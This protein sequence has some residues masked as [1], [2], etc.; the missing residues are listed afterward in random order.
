[1]GRY[2]DAVNCFE[3]VIEL[4]PGSA[5]DY[6]N[7]GI[8]L[9]RLGHTKEAAFVLRQALELDASLDFARQALEGVGGRG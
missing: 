7:L 4:D 9:L 8:N 1:L 2:Q 6:A 5:I 3:K